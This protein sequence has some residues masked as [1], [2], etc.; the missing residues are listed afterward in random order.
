[1]LSSLSEGI[2]VT[3]L[4]AMASRLPIATTDVGGNSEIVIHEE[5]GLLSPRSDPSVLGK[6]LLI[7]SK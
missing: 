4:E 3:L 5:T 1:M 7:A 6:N 2:S